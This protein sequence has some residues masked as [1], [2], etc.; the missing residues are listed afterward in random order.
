MKRKGIIDGVTALV[1]VVAL[2]LTLGC[3]TG[4]IPT[5]AGDRPAATVQAQD[6][7]A[8]VL[9]IG[10]DTYKTAVAQHDAMPICS[11]VIVQPCD[12]PDL[13]AK[14]RAQLLTAAQ[15]L[16]ASW[17]GLIAWKQSGDPLAARTA[18]CDLQKGLPDF[19]ALAVGFGIVKQPD[20]D[21]WLP[22]VST[23]L[24]AAGGC[25]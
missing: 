23:A 11:A 9:K 10:D 19:E 20:A 25:P 2:T 12:V 6:A 1:G 8:D 7:I 24:N 16:R 17:S 22:I 3:A 15:A 18:F 4:T 5:S 13:H 21:K 14:H